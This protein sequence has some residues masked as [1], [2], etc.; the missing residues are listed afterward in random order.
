MFFY[1]INYILQHYLLQ[2]ENND[3]LTNFVKTINGKEEG[4]YVLSSTALFKK[5]VLIVMFC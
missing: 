5:I 1:Y 3:K 2:A 4:G